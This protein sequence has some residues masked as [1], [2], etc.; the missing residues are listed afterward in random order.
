MQCNFRTEIQS[1]DL[2]LIT[3]MCNRRYID[4][5]TENYRDVFVCLCVCGVTLT[6]SQLTRALFRP[7]SH[8]YPTPDSMIYHK[9]IFT[10]RFMFTNLTITL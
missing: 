10:T 2:I 5:A 6:S 1:Y 7:S 4:K 3:Y 9:P 8:N